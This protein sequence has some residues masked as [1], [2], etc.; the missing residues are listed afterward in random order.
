M[1][2]EAD[3]RPAREAAGR[4]RARVVVARSVTLFRDMTLHVVRNVVRSRC[5]LNAL[6]WMQR[7]SRSCAGADRARRDDSG[8]YAPSECRAPTRGTTGHARD[9]AGHALDLF[10]RVCL[11]H[12]R[13]LSQRCVKLNRCMPLHLSRQYRVSNVPAPR[14]CLSVDTMR[15]H[16]AHR[17]MSADAG[18]VTA[19]LVRSVGQPN[20]VPIVE[21]PVVVGRTG[22]ATS[23]QSFR[24]MHAV[25]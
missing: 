19:R 20:T 21:E 10:D 1:H 5:I 17:T 4:G 15:F 24:S 25:P 7:R 18:W 6:A 13:T 22:A 8:R 11:R 23:R 16:P 12:R 3:S 2:R 14:R 9:R